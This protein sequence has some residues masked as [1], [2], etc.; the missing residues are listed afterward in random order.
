MQGWAV[1]F[2]LVPALVAAIELVLVRYGTARIGLLVT[3][4]QV[5]LVPAIFWAMLTTYMDWVQKAVP[6]SGK[7]SIAVVASGIVE[8]V[9]AAAV[10]IVLA[11][12]SWTAYGFSR[13]GSVDGG[14]HG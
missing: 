10:V 12:A 6:A 1:A 11:L 14:S 9:L 8:P 2:W 7:T 4:A 5:I 3:P 13:G